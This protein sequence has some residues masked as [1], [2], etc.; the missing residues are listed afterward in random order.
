MLYIRNRGW[1][2][3][4]SEVQ[5]DKAEMDE[6]GSRSAQYTVR[7]VGRLS[8]N[9]PDKF[10]KPRQL[11][12]P[13]RVVSRHQIQVVRTCG[14]PFRVGGV[15]VPAEEVGPARSNAIALIASVPDRRT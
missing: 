10:D 4:T 5:C 13:I 6:R 12:G 15:L 2:L 7:P 1:G 3:W 8:M 9:S 11:R 14:H